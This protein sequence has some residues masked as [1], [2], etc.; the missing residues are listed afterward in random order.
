MHDPNHLEVVIANFNVGDRRTYAFIPSTNEVFSIT[1]YDA[2]N[3][4]SDTDIRLGSFATLDESGTYYAST[5][6][7]KIVKY[8]RIYWIPK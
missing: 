2:D 5:L 3:P 7:P 8:G 1:L 4:F 6:I